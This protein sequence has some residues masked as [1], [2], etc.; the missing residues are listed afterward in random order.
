MTEYVLL[1]REGDG[2]RWIQLGSTVKAHSA[3]AAIRVRAEGGDWVA[4]PARSWKVLTV[5][6]EKI[7]RKTLTPAGAKPAGASA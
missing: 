2:A 7:E 6:V 3:A 5:E 1:S 4:I